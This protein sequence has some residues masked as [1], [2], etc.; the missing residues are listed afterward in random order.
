MSK[1][2]KPMSP[3]ISKVGEFARFKV[4]LVEIECP[5]RQ[6]RDLLC[7]DILD[8]IPDNEFTRGIKLPAML[9]GVEAKG[10]K[11]L[12]AVIATS[13]ARARTVVNDYVASFLDLYDGEAHEN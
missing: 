2:P 3:A 5:H 1:K 13:A 6:V 12:V 11:V 4:H 7:E 9:V 10:R 8:N